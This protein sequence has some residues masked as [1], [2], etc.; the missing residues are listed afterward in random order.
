[1]TNNPD[2]CAICKINYYQNGEKCEESN[3]YVVFM[4]T[5]VAKAGI[6]FAFFFIFN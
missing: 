5:W 6:V 4:K 2:Q 1:M 3:E